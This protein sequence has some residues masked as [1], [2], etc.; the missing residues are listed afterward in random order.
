[1]SE[2]SKAVK[3]PLNRSQKNVFWLIFISISLLNLFGNHIENEFL[4]T[5]TKPFIVPFIAIYFSTSWQE[6]S[7]NSIIYKSMMIG[8]FFAWLGDLY[9]MFSVDMEIMVLALVSFLICHI[10]YSIALFFSSVKGDYKWIFIVTLPLIA[11]GAFLGHKIGGNDKVMAVPVMLYS[12][13]ISIMFSFTVIRMFRIKNI[14]GVLTC[15]GGLLF[16]CSDMMIGF[17]NFQSYHIPET[18]IMVAYILSQV[19]ITRGMLTEG[20]AKA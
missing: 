16:I 8:F 18:Y 9:M 14:W 11:V 3:E 20:E 1:M 12:I 15:I 19:C 17:K 13:V 4:I 10:L 7:E 5:Y 2:S 6:K